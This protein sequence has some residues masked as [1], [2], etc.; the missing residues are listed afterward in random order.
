MTLLKE[1][2]L[3]SESVAKKTTY[4]FT[5]PKNPGEGRF[6]VLIQRDTSPQKDTS[7]TDVNSLKPVKAGVYT[8]LE[9]M[10]AAGYKGNKGRREIASKFPSI[11]EGYSVQDSDEFIV[12][13]DGKASS[14][15][16]KPFKI[17]PDFIK[18]MIAN[19]YLVKK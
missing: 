4:V 6:L 14:K 19:K 17:N 16:G 7:L 11:Y 15:F 12:S 3:L 5:D 2:T 10:K 9:L 18:W 13:A 1:I 8:T